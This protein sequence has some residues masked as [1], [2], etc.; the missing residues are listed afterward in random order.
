MP[1]RSPW[2]ASPGGRRRPAAGGRTGATPGATRPRRGAST[3]RRPSARRPPIPWACTISRGSVTSGARTGTTRAITPS[4]RPGTPAVRRP[5][6][7]GSAGAE[8]GAMPTPGARS[9]T[10]PPCRPT[11]A[12][13][14]TVFALRATAETGLRCRG[15]DPMN[16]GERS[17]VR[18]GIV[19]GLIGAAVVAIWFFVFDLMRGK[20]FITPTLLGSMV[21]FGVK[22]PVGLEPALGPII[23]Y[24]ILFACFEVFFF[25]MLSV[26]GRAAQAALVWWSVLIGNLLA[27]VAMIW[28]FFRKYRG[29]PKTLIGSW[30]GVL[31]EG[32]VAGIIGAVVMA[33]AERYPMLIFGLVI[34]FTAFEVF[35]FGGIV[36]VASWV[37]DEVAG[38]TIFVGNILA[39]GSMLAYYFMHHRTLTSR[40]AHSWAE[41]E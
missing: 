12:T 36:I 24:T 6:L 35:F 14:T 20:P 28:F 19:A 4:R 32:I 22:T 29:L 26:L 2:S 17:V 16:P 5:A 31:R 41:E 34:L 13:R 39:A 25:G 7:A 40:L 1:P 30:G 10:G 8:P 33:G 9:P 11:C 37:L 3:R 21:F 18:E 38:W 15:Y 27:S 23:G